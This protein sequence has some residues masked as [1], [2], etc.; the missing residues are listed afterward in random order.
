M[1]FIDHDV[2]E[3]RNVLR[4]NFTEHAVGCFKADALSFRLNAAFGLDITSVPAAF[5]AERFNVWTAG[6]DRRPGANLII[7]AVDNHLARQEIAQVV[8]SSHGRWYCLDLGNEHHSG[9]VL[10]GNVT[11]P[12]EIKF[13]R[14]GL[15]TG[16]PSPYI[17]EPTLLEPPPADADPLSCADM[18][19][20]EEQSLV[21]N[22][23]VAA[24]GAHYAYQFLVR[25]EL[26]QMVTEFTLEPPTTR[27]RWITEANV[28]SC[29]D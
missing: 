16:L 21:V 26:T 29:I 9:Q 2:V 4:Q 7:S 19:L 6:Y 20:R 25:R 18:M 17:Q 10:L 23:Q 22:Q 24:L 5:S 14:L 27:S 12:D 28:H 8:H 1:L 11:D 13:D 15:C 3:H